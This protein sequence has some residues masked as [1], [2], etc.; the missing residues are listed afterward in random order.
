MNAASTNFNFSDKNNNFYYIVKTLGINL[1]KQNKNK[2]LSISLWLQ[3]CQLIQVESKSLKYKNI[4]SFLSAY[5]IFKGLDEEEKV[6]LFN[7]A[8]WM[9]VLLTMI[10]AKGNKGLL[11]T[12]RMIAN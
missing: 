11:I 4:D 5:V 9:N 7:F 6:K 3:Y 10:P 12:V 2:H 8:N 1:K